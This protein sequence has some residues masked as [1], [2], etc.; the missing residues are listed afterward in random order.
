MYSKVD[1]GMR[2][3]RVQKNMPAEAT[4]TSLAVLE[5]MNQCSPHLYICIYI[6]ICIL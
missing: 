6:N 4:K 1:K 2:G 5:G 3:G